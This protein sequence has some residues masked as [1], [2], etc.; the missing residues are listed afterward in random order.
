MRKVSG[1]QIVGAVRCG[2]RCSRRVLFL[3]WSPSLSSQLGLKFTYSRHGKLF[4][5]PLF[6]LG[7]TLLLLGGTLSFF[8]RAL[9]L[10][11]G[12]HE[13]LAARA[14]SVPSTVDLKVIRA[15]LRMTQA[16]F[17]DTFGFT[18]HAVRHWEQGT[19]TPEGAARVLLTVI[20]REPGAVV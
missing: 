7:G 3:P 2:F 12:W 6:F 17:A 4:R 19:R 5:S 1:L 13:L 14:F 10:L 20:A 9:F 11:D 8:G 16:Q 15:R 18:L